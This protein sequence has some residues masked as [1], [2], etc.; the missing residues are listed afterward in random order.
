MSLKKIVIIDD[1]ADI[2][3]VAALV[4]ET[5]GSFEVHSASNGR[6]GI[7]LAQRERPDAIL[8]D[9]MMPDMDGP[10]T[11]ARLR[12]FDATRS[13]PVVFLTAKIQPADRLR[14]AETGAAGVIAKPF[15]PLTLADQVAA[16]LQ[17]TG[18]SN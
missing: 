13:T 12:E 6:D 16:F 2:S 7:A 14:L 11:L 9:V 1:E 3:E 5:M 10:T 17:T 8:L 4:L 15:D 18:G